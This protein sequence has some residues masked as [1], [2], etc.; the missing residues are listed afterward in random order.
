MTEREF[1]KYFSYKLFN[2]LCD[3]DMTQHDLANSIN[4]TKQCVSHYINCGRFPKLE[5]LIK[6][7]KV[8]DITVSELLDF[9]DFTSKGG[10]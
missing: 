9:S 4:V 3:N 8:F 5:I 1:K 7:A 6:I 10:M 2:L